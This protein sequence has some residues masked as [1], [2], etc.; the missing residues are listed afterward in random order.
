MIQ[1]TFCFLTSICWNNSDLAEGLT[2]MVLTTNAGFAIA[3]SAVPN[4]CSP[5]V[6]LRLFLWN[7]VQSGNPL[8]TQLSERVHINNTEYSSCGNTSKIT[9]A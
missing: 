3:L 4:G 9:Y 6:T 7:L 5:F 1:D 8:T 2:F